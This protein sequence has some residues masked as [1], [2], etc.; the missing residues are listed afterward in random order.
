MKTYRIA[1]LI[2][3]MEAMGKTVTQAEK[4]LTKNS[5]TAD[6]T[7]TYT[8]ETCKRIL[9]AHPEITEESCVYIM[10]GKA[11]ADGL[12]DYNGLVLHSSAIAY[13]NNAYLFSADSGTGKSTHTN[14]WK[15]CFNGAEVIN[16]DKPALRYIDGKF[17]AYG[18]PFSGST[19]INKNVR[20]PLKAICFLERGETNSIEQI[21]NN[22][23]II[24]LFLPQ[25][26]RHVSKDKANKLFDIMDTL[27][28]NVPFYRL[29]CLPN[30]DA[31]RLAYEIMSK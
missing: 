3:N 7:L 6:I 11:F 12:L 27:I 31:A 2:V 15:Q 5:D 9:E 8:P 14:L 29:T 21:T 20:I 24:K 26:L 4:Y 30:E 23:E 19:P 22:A 10:L 25:T 13:E 1:D 17:Y 28:K 18:T 16:D